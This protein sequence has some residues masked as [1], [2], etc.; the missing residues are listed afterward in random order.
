VATREIAKV[1][2][3][4]DV[5]G[6]DIGGVIITRFDAGADTSFHSDDYLS[7]PAVPGALEAL[8]QL[9]RERFGE[10]VFLVSKC[11]PR[12]QEKTLRWLERRCFHQVTGI[13]PRNVRF[14]RQRSE[15]AG[16]CEELGITHFV[17]DRLEILGSLGSAVRIRY[18][19]QARADEV[20]RFRQFVG[21]VTAV[22]SWQ[23]ILQAELPQ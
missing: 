20:K 16:I 18:L 12:V 19:F 22:G 11:G 2:T 23:E 15:K 14:C 6:V 7:T 8:S 5:L 1:M 4:R 13:D 10:K 3:N 17:D 9:V 21:L